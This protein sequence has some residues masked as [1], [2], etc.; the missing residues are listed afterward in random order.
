MEKKFFDS[1]SSAQCECDHHDQARGVPLSDVEHTHKML[2][3]NGKNNILTSWLT[4]TTIITTTSHHTD[5]QVAG[6]FHL[7]LH[8]QLHLPPPPSSTSSFILD[9]SVTFFHLPSP[10]FLPFFP[11]F[12]PFFLPFFLS[13]IFSSIFLLFN[14][15]FSTFFFSLQ[16]SL[17][18]SFLPS[19]LPSFFPFP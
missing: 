15:C 11:S 18:S 14:L 1:F 9:L 6:E 4:K 17:Q 3:C 13:S 8:L 12:L 5:K 19:F 2:R 16:S 10:S 7:Q